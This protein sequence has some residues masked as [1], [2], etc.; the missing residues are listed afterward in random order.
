M[1]LL[2]TPEQAAVV[3]LAKKKSLLSLTPHTDDAGGES[4]SPLPDPALLEELQQAQPPDRR[5]RSRG[6]RPTFGGGGR[7]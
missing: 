2:V 6:F 3:E 5:S 4:A 7:E 1:A